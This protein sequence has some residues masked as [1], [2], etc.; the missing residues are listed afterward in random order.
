MERRTFLKLGSASAAAL[1]GAVSAGCGGSDDYDFAT[2]R[3]D[4]RNVYYSNKGEVVEWLPEE[5]TVRFF[6]VQDRLQWEYTGENTDLGPLNRPSGAIIHQQRIYVSDFGNSRVIV[7]DLQGQ[8]LFNFAEAGDDPDDFFFICE[9]VIGPDGSLYFC[10]PLNHRIQVFDVDG[11]WLRNFGLPGTE[12]FNL[13]YPE[14]LAFDAQGNIHVVDSGNARVVVFSSA[15]QGIRTYGSYGSERG[16]IL[17]PEGI[18]IDPYGY[19]YVADKG[20]HLIQIYDRDGNFQDRRL[21]MLPGGEYGVPG[22]LMW[23]PDGVL[24]VAC[25]IDASGGMIARQYL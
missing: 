3:G 1:V 5:N 21:A 6:N 16:Q 12:G 25:T 7:L 20:Q 18:A 8:P 2:I 10:D 9:P 4:T 23:R 14:S 11:R 22:E 19:T 17:N 24:H 15:G 13:N